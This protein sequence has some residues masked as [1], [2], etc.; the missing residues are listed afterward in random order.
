M[1]ANEGKNGS[2]LANEHCEGRDR[3]VSLAKPEKS[4]FAF[5]PQ[6]HRPH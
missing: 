4:G 3:E 5:A 2:F 1:R 6:V